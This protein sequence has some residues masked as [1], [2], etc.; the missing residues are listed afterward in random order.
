M[1]KRACST[2]RMITGRE[3]SKYSGKRCPSVTLS[4]KNPS[5]TTLGLNLG[6]CSKRLATAQ[7]TAQSGTNGL[8][9]VI[10]S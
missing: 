1:V 7:D 3:K 10:S 2:D 8:T 4:I 5:Y 9:L 6:L